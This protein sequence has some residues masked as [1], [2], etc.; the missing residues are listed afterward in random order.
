M[1]Y[2]EQRVNLAGDKYL[3]SDPDLQCSSDLDRARRALSAGRE[4]I[5][6][7]LDDRRVGI[8]IE[9]DRESKSCI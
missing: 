6:M 3:H 1:F 4:R 8:Y 5:L 7:W 2:C 9:L